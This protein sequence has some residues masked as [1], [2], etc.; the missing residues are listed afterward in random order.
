MSPPARWEVPANVINWWMCLHGND[1]VHRWLADSL[2]LAASC[3]QAWRLHIEGF[4][5]GGSLSCVLACRRADGSPVVLKLLAPWAAEAI[6]PEALALAAWNGHGAAALLERTLDGRALLLSRVSPGIA[7]SPSGSD[8]LDCERVAGTLRVLA[9]V[10]VPDELPPLSDA[11]RARFA[12]ARGMAGQRQKWVTAPDL[13]DAEE[14]AVAL[15]QAAGGRGLVHGDAQDK[16]LLLSDSDGTL[17]AIDP[18]PSVGDRHFDP[19]LW[20]LTHRP[21]VGVR[22]RCAA[23]ASLLALD[24]ARLWDWCLVLAVAEVALEVEDR[25]RAHHEFLAQASRDA[26]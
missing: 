6:G 22:E 8:E 16:N 2:V 9:S 7:F 15:A 13:D 4:L 20:A 17:V 25:A 18:E 12:R 23:L 5:P 1:V 14:R 3:Q 21:G 19:A 10:P 24:E 26:R 11:L